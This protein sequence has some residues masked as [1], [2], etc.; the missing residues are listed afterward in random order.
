[1]LYFRIMYE[2]LHIL[3]SHTWDIVIYNAENVAK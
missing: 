1:M 3:Y 2:T